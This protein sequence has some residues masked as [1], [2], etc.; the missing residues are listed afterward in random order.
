MPNFSS[1][2]WE[3]TE[4]Y[5]QGRSSRNS[6]Y[7]EKLDRLPI[8]LSNTCHGTSTLQICKLMDR[9]TC[10]PISE[11]PRMFWNTSEETAFPELN[12]KLI[13][14]ILFNNIFFQIHILLQISCHFLFMLHALAGRNLHLMKK[15]TSIWKVKQAE[16]R[17]NPELVARVENQGSSRFVGSK[18]NGRL[19]G[20]WSYTRVKWPIDEEPK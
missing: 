9:S 7:T 15:Q 8:W 2:R 16:E 19:F 1:F 6:R 4:I 3:I 17:F 12:Q 5:R 13:V 20:K 11:A 18:W 10:L 14:Y